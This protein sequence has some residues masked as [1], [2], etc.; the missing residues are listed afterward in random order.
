MK[1]SRFQKLRPE[2]DV[3][4]FNMPG[5][6]ISSISDPSLATGVTLF[7]FDPGATSNYDSRGGSVAAVE[8]TLLDEASYSNVVDG[9]IFAGGSTMGLEASQGVRRKIFQSNNEKAGRFDL[10]PSIPGAVVYDF[11][12]RLEKDQN[13]LIFPTLAMGGAAYTLAQ[14]HQML[15][16]RAGAGTSTT[17]NKISKPIWGGQGCAFRTVELESGKHTNLFVAVVLNPRGNIVSSDIN[18]RLPDIPSGPKQNTTLSLVV[19]DL[20]LDRSQLKRLA[21]TVHSSMGKM[22]SPFNT[23]S[24]GDILFTVSLQK[25]KFDFSDA[26]A[27]ENLLQRTATDLMSEAII[28]SIGIANGVLKR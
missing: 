4:K 5:L 24:D 8:T 10:I 17:A 27:S 3:F 19:T 21:V 23:Y 22:I 12:A 26:F 1:L 14:P 9:I 28:R 2:V 25:T 18:G 15:V 11:G 20:S 16:G 13:Q 7:L 6:K